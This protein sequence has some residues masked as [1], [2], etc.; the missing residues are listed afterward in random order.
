M[1]I[2]VLLGMIGLLLLGVA[3]WR[4]RFAPVWVPA[5]LVL[6]W[7]I[8]FLGPPTV[9]FFTTGWALWLISLGY[10]GLKILQMSD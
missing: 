2:P 9:V 8:S 7:I 1:G 6:G 10:V 5:I 4:A 3:L